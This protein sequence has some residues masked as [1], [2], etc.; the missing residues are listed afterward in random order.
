VIG[1]I[2]RRF[3]QSIF[4]VACVLFIVFFLF[5]LEGAQ[6]LARSIDATPRASQSELDQIIKIYGFNKPIWI[7]MWILFVQYCH[8]DF[9]RSSMANQNASTLIATALPRSLLLIGMSTLFAILVAI[10]LGVYQVVRRNRPDDYVATGLAFIL[11]A[12]PDYVIG[13]VLIL[14]FSEHWH[15][16][17]PTILP[18]ES[19]WQIATSWKQMTLPMLTLSSTTVAA[20]S[21]YMRS[22]MMDSLAEDYIRTARAKGAG[23]MRV[24]FRHAFRNALLPMITLLGLSLPAIAGG[25][26]LTET[27]FNY[28]GMGLLVYTSAMNNDVQV[29][30][31][32]T[33]VAT[34]LTVVGSLLA[35]ILYAVVDPRIR[36]RVA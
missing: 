35:D 33:V 27:V 16:F 34:L 36:Y 12:A 5:H 24:L 31:A 19:I 3:F 8:L 25:A 14:I 21:R 2:V 17:A 23:R 10:P 20:F 15:I 1:Y 32:T 18:T 11:Y 22:S 29:V 4:V 13:V 30:V 28:P 6:A 9:G 26:V 7:Q